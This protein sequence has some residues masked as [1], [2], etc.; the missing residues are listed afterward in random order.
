MKGGLKKY[1]RY[2]KRRFGWGEGIAGSAVILACLIF[3][4]VPSNMDALRQL[5]YLGGFLAMLIGSATV[6]LPA[7]GLAVV[8][9]L[10]ATISSPLLLGVFSGIGATIGEFTGY[11]AGFSGNR[12]IANAKR[13]DAAQKLIL[14]HGA[15]I[16]ATLA[17]IPNPLFDFAG[18]AA[19]MTKMPIWK[20]LAATA[21]GKILKCIAIA[22]AGAL[23]LDWIKSLYS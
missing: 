7:P 2:I 3:W 9:A 13:Y 18:A 10:G 4:F 23:S 8:L 16:I 19:G 12:I 6:V 14:K 21:V 17:F 11:L 15:I 5:G 1:F 20:F 22:Y